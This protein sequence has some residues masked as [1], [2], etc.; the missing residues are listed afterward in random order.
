MTAQAGRKGAVPAAVISRNTLIK[1]AVKG[2]PRTSLPA[3]I[4]AFRYADIPSN[5]LFYTGGCILTDC[6]GALKSDRLSH[7]P[8]IS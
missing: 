2:I 4:P 7:G 6:I 3:G 8:C 1:I 5:T